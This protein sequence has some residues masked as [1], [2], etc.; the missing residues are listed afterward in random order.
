MWVRTPSRILNLLNRM[1]IYIFLS[2]FICMDKKILKKLLVEQN[3]TQ[4]EIS[5]ELGKSKTTIRYWLC[6]F[7]ISKPKKNITDIKFC[8]RC[9]QTKHVSEFYQRKSRPSVSAYCKRCSNDECLERQRKLKELA[10]NYKGGKCV[11]CGYNK[12]LGAL[13]FH[14][15]D[16][17]KK[18][19]S[20]SASSAKTF[21]EKIKKELDKCMLVCSNCHREIHGRRLQN[22]T[23]KKNNTKTKVNKI[24]PKYGSREIYFS[25]IKKNWLIEQQKYIDEILNS[26]ID[27]T[28]FGWVTQVSKI[29][30][31]KPQRVCYWM[32]KVM[33]EFYSKCFRRKN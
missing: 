18:D 11:V 12:Y 4:K 10:V 8:H 15:T 28:K 30:N 29:I 31:Q 13:E 25:S 16:P 22:I 24:P 27:F 2:I 17:T 6:K 21:N 20:I 33:P 7:K 14:H 19:F 32:E 23:L 1:S 3:K 26:N 5:E 9:N